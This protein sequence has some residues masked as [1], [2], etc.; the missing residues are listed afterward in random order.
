MIRTTAIAALLAVLLPGCVA[1]PEPP[2]TA[3]RVAAA[4]PDSAVY[5]PHVDSVRLPGERIYSRLTD[6]EWYARGEP[7]QHEGAAYRPDGRPV[8]AATAEMEQV[9][10]Y[11]GVEYYRRAGDAE[12][13]L[14]IP[15]FHGYWQPFRTAMN[16]R[17]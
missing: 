11:A 15:V 3:E 13:L 16:D 17:P 8:A 14:Y 4:T 12:P 2:A 10:D 6:H 5:T 9:G 1:E 7:L